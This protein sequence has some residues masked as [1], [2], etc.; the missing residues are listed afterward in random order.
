MEL[1][2]IW[3]GVLLR[4]VGIYVVHKFIT[5]LDGVA[6]TGI[7]PSHHGQEPLPAGV[8]YVD[9]RNHETTYAGSTAPPDYIEEAKQ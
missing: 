8:A 3:G 1:L 2:F 7:L 4:S 9:V 5:E 6:A